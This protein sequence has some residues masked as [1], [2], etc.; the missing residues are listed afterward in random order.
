MIGW[1]IASAAEY[2]KRRSAPAFQLRIFPSKVLLTMASSEEATMAARR[3]RA[4]ISR[5][6]SAR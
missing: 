1:P 5:S 4:C 2:P 6:R 3:A